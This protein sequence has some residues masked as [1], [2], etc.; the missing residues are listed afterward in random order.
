M[1][2]EKFTTIV[3]KPIHE[4]LYEAYLTNINHSKHTSCVGTVLLRAGDMPCHVEVRQ[5]AIQ[6]IIENEEEEEDEGN[7][8]EEEDDAK[9]NHVYKIHMEIKL[10]TKCTGYG[11]KSQV[12][13][14]VELGIYKSNTLPLSFF[15][16]FEKDMFEKLK[17]LTFDNERGVFM[18][19]ENEEYFKMYFDFS[20][21]PKEECSVCYEETFSK[22]SC[23]HSLCS[24]CLLAIDKK[25]EC[26]HSFLCPIC[27][28]NL[29]PDLSSDDED[30]CSVC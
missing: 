25:A 18:L 22:T 13:L 8:D 7:D 4:L 14:S 1:F 23:G 16:E 6:R 11:K 24:I 5:Y 20:I 27:R 2:L 3:F 30:D 17:K 21:S 15:K 28:K 29:N 26:V 12:P 19:P 10:K 9:C